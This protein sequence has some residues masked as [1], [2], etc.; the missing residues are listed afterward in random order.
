MTANDQQYYRVLC[1]EQGLSWTLVHTGQYTSACLSQSRFLGHNLSGSPR[2][3]VTGATDGYLGFWNL[4]VPSAAKSTIQPFQVHRIHQSTIK[5]LASASYHAREGSGTTSLIFTGGD[6]NALAVTRADIMP[7]RDER[8]HISVATLLIPRAHAAAVTA[9]TI[10]P[11]AS[12]SDATPGCRSTGPRT[13]TL[14]T[15][16]NDQRVK[17][18]RFMIDLDVPGVEGIHV[19]K[20]SNDYTPVADAGCIELIERTSGGGRGGVGVLVCGVGMDVRGLNGGER[21]M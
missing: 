20:M 2:Y 19:E 18:W 15:A 1:T 10:L 12:S 17:T 5:S 11:L 3:L 4:Q 6:D 8:P 21:A 9:L 7:P 13:V 14:A 16:S